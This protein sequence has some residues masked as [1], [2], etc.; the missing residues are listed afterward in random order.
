[1]EISD[2]AVKV[3]GDESLRHIGRQFVAAVHSNVTIDWTLPEN[4]PAT[5]DPSARYG[6]W[7][8]TDGFALWYDLKYWIDEAGIAPEPFEE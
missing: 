4:V 7:G 5:S 1:M 2:G 6:T 8:V 3:L